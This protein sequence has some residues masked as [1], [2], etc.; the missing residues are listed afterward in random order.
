MTESNLIHKSVKLGKNVSFEKDTVLK[1]G[2][3]VGNNVSFYKGVVVGEDSHIF[4]GAVIGRPP[5]ATAIMNRKISKVVKP[6]TIGKGS[7]IGANT[8]LY[9]DIKIGVNVLVGDL[10]T[11]REGCKFADQV[12]IGRSVLV[13]YDTKVGER[14]RVIDGAILTGNMTIEEDVFI[15]PGA[16]SINDGTPYLIRYGLEEFKV[17]GPVVR[18]FA[19][20]G[21]GATLNAG[22]EIGTG[23]IVAPNAMVTKDVAAWTVVAGVPAKIKRDVAKGAKEKILRHFNLWD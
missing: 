3:V 19:L 21:T 4:D 17:R 6:T 10:A 15:G 2:V 5:K 8:V 13:M 23:A 20:I 16:N 18:R 7:I 1:K 12:V 22:I 9:N 14:T 11:I